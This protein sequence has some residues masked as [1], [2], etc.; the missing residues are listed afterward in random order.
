MISV[1]RSTKMMCGALLAS[2]CTVAAPQQA[3]ADPTVIGVSA[4]INGYISQMSGNHVF[5]DQNQ[6]FVAPA[7]SYFI[8][9]SSGLSNRPGWMFEMHIDWNPFNPGFFGPNARAIVDLAIKPPTGPN[10]ITSVF[11][12]SGQGGPLP[13]I[14]QTDGGNIHIDV[15]VGDL[16]AGGNQMFIQWNQ[17]IPAPGALA[18]LG[19]A[20]LVGSRRRR[21]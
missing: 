13:G 18:L 6:A 1:N 4:N 17:D 11:L 9:V 5:G 19:M 14:V 10:P 3:S 8:L 12:K 20:G 16:V 15:S 21:A 7:S 2:I